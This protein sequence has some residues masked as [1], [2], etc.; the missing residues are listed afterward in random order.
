MKIT[1]TR[2]TAL[3]GV[4]NDAHP[5]D[6]RDLPDSQ[7]KQ[8]IAQG[9]AVAGGEFKKQTSR[10]AARPAAGSAA[11]SAQAG[12]DDENNGGA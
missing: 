11:S 2:G 5:G 7:A 3:G 6:V 10:Q 4:G 1:F 9:R 12:D 8:L